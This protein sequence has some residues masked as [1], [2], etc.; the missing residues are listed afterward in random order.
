MIVLLAIGA[1]S[2]LTL[3]SISYKEYCWR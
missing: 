3:D 2:T 1:L